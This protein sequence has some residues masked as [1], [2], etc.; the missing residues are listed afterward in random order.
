MKRTA[1]SIVLRVRDSSKP[2]VS[3]HL[4]ISSA[5]SRFTPSSTHTVRPLKSSAVQLTIGR[6]DGGY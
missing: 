1:F 5:L 6:L 2:V 4:Y 3:V